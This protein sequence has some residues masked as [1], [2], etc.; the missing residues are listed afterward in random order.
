MK[1]L[2]LAVLVLSFSSL[3]A[4]HEVRPAFLRI[5]KLQTDNLGARYE[6]SL[7]Q[8]QVDGRFLGL[9]LASNCEAT[10]LS[11]RITDGALIEVS[12]LNCPEEGLQTIEIVGLERT[13]VDALVSIDRADG[14]TLELLITGSEPRIDLADATPSLP[15][16]LTIGVEHLLF[17]FD[18]VLF[19]IML[20][21]LV[22][23]TLE[24]VKVVTSFTLAHSLTLALSALDIVTLSP[25][26]IE[27]VIAGSI[28]LLAYENLNDKTSLIKQYPFLVA[29]AF[30]LLHGLGFA[31]A[32]SQ[33]GLPESGTIAALFLFNVGIELGQLA[34]IAL[35]VTAL[36]VF[37]VKYNRLA[38]VSP[39]YFVGC[40]SSFWFIQRSWQILSPII[41]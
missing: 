33:I 38:Y 18:H 28:V 22:R 32:L 25:A 16:Y 8:P 13:L 12:E 20:L 40:I 21:Y 1:K 6:A 29:F 24:I 23:N 36:A 10:P 39:I 31:G 2:L 7:R 37:R 17:G 15:V 27:A 5:A 11:T 4:A 19:V 26:P 3:A 14:E 34:I 41:S 30:G 35:V 9:E